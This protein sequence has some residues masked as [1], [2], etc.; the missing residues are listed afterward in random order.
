MS[1]L[2]AHFAAHYESKLI[3]G[4]AIRNFGKCLNLLQI[5]ILNRRKNRVLG[6]LEPRKFVARSCGSRLRMFYYAPK[7]AAQ[8]AETVKQV[9]KL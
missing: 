5:E 7:F 4:S 8:I 3:Y 2:A 6:I 1:L 9:Q